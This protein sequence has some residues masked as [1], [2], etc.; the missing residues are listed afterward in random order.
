[1][2]SKKLFKVDDKV[3]AKIRG[4]PAWPAI[5]SGVKSA[6]TPSK[7]KYNVFFYGTGERA[8]CKPEDLCPYEENKSKL[9][10]PNKRKYFVEALKQI[11]NDFEIH[12]HPKNDSQT[13]ISPSNSTVEL[14]K[15]SDV[16]ENVGKTDE[17][18]EAN[19]DTE[20][21][22][23]NYESPLS[24]TKK[25]MVAKKS[26]GLSM[27]K[28]T[29]RKLSDVKPEG[30]SKKS[31]TNKI[32]TSDQFRLKHKHSRPIILVEKLKDSLIE[33]IAGNQVS[34]LNIKSEFM[35]KIIFLIKIIM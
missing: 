5:V 11:E 28:G 4:Y 18:S 26:L 9:G 23:T 27:S 20:E 6:D 33:Q 17:I 25:V 31:M 12:D 3:F 14:E 10:K 19:L 15:P 8:D 13:L 32:R 16:I 1:M 7:T 34:S 35:F 24:K 22:S 21:K 30:S 2:S 29:K